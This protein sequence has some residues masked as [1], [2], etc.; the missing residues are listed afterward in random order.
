M[1]RPF[2]PTT[3]SADPQLAAVRAHFKEHGAALQNAATLV[4]GDAG[5]A[6]VLRLMSELRAASHLNRPM[7][8]R[9]VALHRLLSLD[10]VVEEFEPDLSSWV[11]LDPASPEVEQ[12]CLLTDGLFDLLTLINELD[13]QRDSGSVTLTA[14]NVA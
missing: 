11:L 5:A 3:L 13:N 14:Q 12:I 6:S 2:I 4:N 9:L 7:R 1:L 8:R 10:T